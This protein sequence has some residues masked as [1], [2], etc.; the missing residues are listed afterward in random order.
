MLVCST[1]SGTLAYGSAVDGKDWP[2][3]ENSGAGAS[4]TPDD[5]DSRVAATIPT[6]KNSSPDDLLDGIDLD[7]WKKLYSVARDEFENRR[8]EDAEK[9]LLGAIKA[10]KHGGNAERK[11]IDSRNT[12][13]DL[14][15][16]N[17]KIEEAEK[18]YLWCV[19]AARHEDGAESEAEAHAEHGLASVYLIKGR[20][21]EAH[22]LCKNAV[23][24]RSKLLGKH[25][26]E[27]GQSLILMGC[28][29]SR[30]GFVDEPAK[31]FSAGLSVLSESPGVRQLDLADALRLTAIYKDRMGEKGDGQPLFQQSYAI[32]DKSVDFD[33]T[34]KVKGRV[35]FQW[36]DGSPRSQEIPDPEVPLRY[37]CSNNVR[38]ACTVI[39][40]WELFGVLISV[41]NV[42]DRRQDIG[43]GKV[44]FVR[45]SGDPLDPKAEPL[46][47]ID[48]T[49]I[50]RV[51]REIDIWR[52]TS[53]KPWL[54]NMQKT[55]N[56]RGLVPAHGHD[57]F[58]GPNIF[59]VYG[60]WGASAR[61]L[62][63]KFALEPSPENVEEQ[64]KVIVD[65]GMVHTNDNRI[66]GLIP[67]SLEP[68]ESRTGELFYMNPRCEHVLLRVYVGNT[69]FEFPFKTPKH[70]TAT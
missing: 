38:V 41:T 52:L 13:A 59:G 12:L 26:R 27:Y 33:Q 40:L 6:Q 7:S 58:R 54:A 35:R 36:E 69:V 17:D 31:F 55:R 57:L 23:K 19:A 34:A 21:S 11:L 49:H 25:S 2:S 44:Q 65:P 45:T 51:R 66:L 9:S 68:F 56:I 18:L 37:F 39:D 70:R 46:E 28:I 8:Y 47:L 32:K 64:A 15:Y 60:E 24:T 10:A 53:N 22:E 43:L 63:E 20:Y 16:A 48:P 50:D 42:G 62:P 1:F 3:A 29:L 67:V 61:V 4:A 5:S 30:E 14:Y